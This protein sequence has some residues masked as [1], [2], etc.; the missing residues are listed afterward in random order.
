MLVSLYSALPIQSTSVRTP[1]GTEEPVLV[2][3]SEEAGWSVGSSFFGIPPGAS[4]TITYELSGQLA[5]VTPYRLA[6]RPQPIVIDEMLDVSVRDADGE[7]LARSGP[8]VEAMVLH[9]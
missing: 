2:E 5:S 9:E 4:I 8:S 6:V 1:D 3:A 7:V